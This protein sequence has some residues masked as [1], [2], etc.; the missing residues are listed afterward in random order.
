MK[1]ITVLVA[2]TL[3]ASILGSPSAE[4]GPYYIT[5]NAG[6]SKLKDFC[7]SPAAGFTC[8][9]SASAYGLDGG[10]QFSDMFGLEL[11]YANYGTP[12]TSG[13]LFG[14][15]LKVTEEISGLRFSGTA[16]FPISNSFAFTGKLGVSRNSLNVISTVTPGPVIPAYTASSTSLAYGVGVKYSINESVALRVQY[17]NLGKTGDETIGTDTLSLLTVGISYNFGKSGRFGKS[18]PRK[19]ANKPVVQGQPATAQPAT[20]QPAMHVIVFLENAPP[21]DK[22][23]LTAAIAEACKCEPIFVRLYS[24][25]AVTYQISLA[26][27]QTFLTFK[28]ALL[29]GDPSLGLKTLMQGQ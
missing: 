3:M 9:D 25:N 27:G 23:L 17:E 18:G 24:S 21:V 8:K 6:L 14:S 29:P 26:P 5:V 11:A 16:T 7:S 22:R 20:A 10:Y 28:S 1:K 12:E 13:L 15:N 2:A 19:I 4:A